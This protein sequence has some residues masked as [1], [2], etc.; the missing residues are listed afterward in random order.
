MER[1]GPKPT[2]SGLFNF[3]DI[4]IEALQS[5]LAAARSRD[6][7]QCNEVK[8]LVQTGDVVLQMRKSILRSNVQV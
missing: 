2:S 6:F 8:L 3:N 5:A 4:E 1:G 7:D